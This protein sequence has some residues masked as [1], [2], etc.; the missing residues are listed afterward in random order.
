VEADISPKR[1]DSGFAGLAALVGPT[2]QFNETA[3]DIGG[4]R[5]SA[6]PNQRAKHHFS[7]VS[8]N[9]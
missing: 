2:A 9:F 5:L 4:I 8:Q 1:V 7:D 6:V 3:L